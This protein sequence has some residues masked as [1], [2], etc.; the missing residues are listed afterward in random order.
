MRAV[1]EELTRIAIATAQ[2][3]QPTSV[4]LR[5]A[6][7]IPVT[8]LPTWYI[9]F[10]DNSLEGVPWINPSSSF[11]TTTGIYTVPQEGVYSFAV[12]LTVPAFGGGNKE[13]YAGIR[14]TIAPLSGPPIETIQYSG[15]IDS[16]PLTVTLS[17]TYP[18]AQGGQAAW[19]ATVVHENQ[20]GTVP[21]DAVL[22]INRISGLG[23]NTA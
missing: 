10:A 16:T 8:L 23:D 22:Q 12:T 2:L 13:Y 19:D 15:G 21:F 3:D 18:A 11:D 4:G 20:L 7:D 9:L 17:W 1:W 14:M 6:G 5:S